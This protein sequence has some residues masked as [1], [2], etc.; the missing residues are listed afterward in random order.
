[1]RFVRCSFL[2]SVSNPLRVLRP[3]FDILP[4]SLSI[5]FIYHGSL[6]RDHHL[7]V[8]NK[9]YNKGGSYFALRCQ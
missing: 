6:L 2:C 4:G 9:H 7:L 3:H 1:M 8:C 5:G